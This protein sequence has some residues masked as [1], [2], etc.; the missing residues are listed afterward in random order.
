MN[1]IICLEEDRSETGFPNRVVFEI[2][3]IEP[4]E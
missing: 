2:E 4:V 1:E 3:L